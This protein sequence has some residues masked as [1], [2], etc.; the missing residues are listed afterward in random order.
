M[1][2]PPDPAGPGEGDAAAPTPGGGPAVRPVELPTRDPRPAAVLCALWEDPDGQA[3][4]IVTRR[5]GRLRSHTG[6]V[7]FP[8]GRLDAGE[9]ALDAALREAE[10][11]VGLDPSAVEVIG[12]LS[13]LSTYTSSEGIT[14]FV[15]ALDAPPRLSPNPAE[16]ERV[17]SVRLAEL[18]APGVY[19]EERW[20]VYG[21]P[22]RP[23]HFFELAHD[24]VWGAT[25]LLLRELLDRVMVQDAAGAG[26]AAGAQG[27]L[28]S[29]DAPE[30][31][32]SA[33]GYR[34][35]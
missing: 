3:Q 2:R 19:H 21:Q 20:D 18:L 16:V 4:V 35:S 24:T 17:W 29:P 11:E 9:T 5:S 12:T 15:G 33:V 26:G 32:R 8:G 25:A 7:A 31:R 28:E 22:D 14:A 30:T 13:P 6:E 1:R 34:G 10:E 27:S 23:V